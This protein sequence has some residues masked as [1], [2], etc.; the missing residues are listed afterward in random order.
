MLHK[1]S[2]SISFECI[3]EFN[4]FYFFAKFRTNSN[5]SIHVCE[6]ESWCPIEIDQLPLGNELALM[7][8]AKDY[9]V[10]IKSSVAFPYFGDKYM[11]NNLVGN[12]GKP[13]LFKQDNET[14]ENNGCQ[15]FKLGDIVELAGG[16]FSRFS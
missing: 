14:G 8:D 3:L 10:F 12:N 16:N 13:C 7:A 9:T 4:N 2:L 11:R 6:V 15:I 1:L 5:E